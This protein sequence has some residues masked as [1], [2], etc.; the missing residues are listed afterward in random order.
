MNSNL[1]LCSYFVDLATIVGIYLVF[2][3]VIVVSMKGPSDKRDTSSSHA[4]SRAK[5]NI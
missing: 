3:C 5:L 2:I 4:K 1:N